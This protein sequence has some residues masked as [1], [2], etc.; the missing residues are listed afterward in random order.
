MREKSMKRSP[1]RHGESAPDVSEVVDRLLKRALN[2][3]GRKSRDTGLVQDIH[4]QLKRQPHPLL[5]RCL[6]QL[7][8]TDIYLITDIAEHFKVKVSIPAGLPASADK[9]IEF[10][11]PAF[12]RADLL[13]EP[14]DVDAASE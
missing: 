13:S 6:V 10:K 9:S 8:G 11:E 12:T 1:V 7:T 14:D 4:E 5:Q 2:V 3:F